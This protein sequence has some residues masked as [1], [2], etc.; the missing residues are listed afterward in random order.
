[1]SANGTFY[2]S[3]DLDQLFNVTNPTTGYS[4]TV[5]LV[6]MT[7]HL[8]LAVGEMNE[9]GEAPKFKKHFLKFASLNPIL[10]V[11]APMQG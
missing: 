11:S 9:A 5:D 4:E 2:A 10:F 6:G 1:M 3:F 7:Y 8:L